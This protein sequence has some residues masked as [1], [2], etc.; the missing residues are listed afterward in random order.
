MNPG[1]AMVEPTGNNT[2][3]AYAAKAG[4]AA[5]DGDSDHSPFTAALLN[6]LFAPGLDVRLALGRARDEVLGKTRNQQEPFVYGSLGGDNIALVPG[7]EQSPKPA[8]DLDRQLADYTEVDKIDT[9]GGW[10]AFLAH[11][12]TGFYAELARERL[13]V[14]DRADKAAAEIAQRLQAERA[15]LAAERAERDRLERER[16]AVQQQMEQARLAAAQAERERREAERAVSEQAEQARAEAAAA[17]K[18][19]EPAPAPSGTNTAA[20]IALLTPPAEPTPPQPAKTL[21]GGALVVA[22]KQELKRVGC[23]FGS[24]DD[25]W[26]SA[27]TKSSLGEFV[28][29]ARL[30]DTPHDPAL[31][32]LNSV[33]GKTG[34]VCPLQCGA[35]E[36][37]K[38]GECVV[39]LC[40]SGTTLDR[41]GDCERNKPEKSPPRQ[42]ARA[43]AAPEPAPQVTPGRG[44]GRLNLPCRNPH[45]HRLPGG[46]CGY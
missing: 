7:P 5:D 44:T 28:K 16:A 32:F 26:T 40:P 29:Y 13:A 41:D 30:P 24:I 22:I 15:R 35:R 6:N 39:K 45:W 34:R 23:Y 9:R 31:D 21:A 12:P 3:I 17:A 43:E 11:Y 33:R 46:G 4:S 18:P 20:K 14:L 25:N 8:V 36:V 38:D 2:L 10:D 42:A 1:L 37:E 27:E 19:A